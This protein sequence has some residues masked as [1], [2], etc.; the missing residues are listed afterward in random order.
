MPGLRVIV[1]LLLSGLCSALH[2]ECAC[3]WQGSFSDVQQS[4]D[5]V[6]AA[7]VLSIKGNAVDVAVE[8]NLRGRNYL[9]R[10]RV[11]METRDYCRPPAEDFPVG[12]RW[13]FALKR[14]SEVPSDGFDSSTPNQSF[15]RV[16]DYYLSS[17]GGYWLNYSGEAVTGN[18][19]NAPRW[20]R[21]PDMTPVLMD[22]L[23]AFLRSEASSEA[24]LEASREDPAL[25]D[26]MLDTKAFLRGD[27]GGN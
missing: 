12:S 15:G 6:I 7:K 4:A 27:E 18:L 5:L 19:V 14:I 23:R 26:L 11:W 17:C 2:A 20:A 21:D 9:D 8:E 13:V 22:L 25:T 10:V 16:D 3:L 24:L 1:A